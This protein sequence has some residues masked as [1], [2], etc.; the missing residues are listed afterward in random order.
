MKLDDKFIAEQKK[1]LQQRRQ[2]ILKTLNQDAVPNKKASNDFDAKF[3]EY[4]D[5]DDDNAAEVAVY[6]ENLTMEKNLELS[7]FNVDKALAK[8]ADGNYGVC[9]KC[10]S[11]IDV[12]RLEAFP[13]A[14]SCMNC[15][16]KVQ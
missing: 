5:K 11:P 12:K 13:S 7:L 9:E 14:S 2:Q 15:K 1:K 10:G 3:P 16:R 4:G 6:S 8:I